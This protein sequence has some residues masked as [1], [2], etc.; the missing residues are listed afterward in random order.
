VIA[1]CV[2]RDGNL[3]ELK[4]QAI[5]LNESG[6]AGDDFFRTRGRPRF[7]DAPHAQTILER[8]QNL[9]ARL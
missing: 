3:A 7:A 5:A 4:L 6:D 2:F 8:V 1:D 9:S